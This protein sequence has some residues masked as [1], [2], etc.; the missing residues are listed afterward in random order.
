[1][2]DPLLPDPDVNDLIY[3]RLDNQLSDEDFAAIEERLRTDRK[4]REHFVRLADLD[5]CLY[6]EF[7]ESTNSVTT[8][9]PSTKSLFL[10]PALRGSLLSA[11]ATVI[12]FST[13]YLLK[14][15]DSD[16]VAALDRGI[17]FSPTPAGHS[18]RSQAESVPSSSRKI[19]FVADE[20]LNTKDAAVLV[21]VDDENTGPFL[22]GHRFKPGIVKLTQGYIQL[23]FICG[24]IVGLKGPGELRIESKDAATI[25]SG[26]VAAHVPDRARGFVLHAPSAAIVDLGT[27]FGVRIDESGDAEVKVQKG[28]VELSLL[29]DDGSTLVSERVDDSKAVLVD[30]SLQKLTQR[31]LPSETFPQIQSFD[32]KPL[33]I[34]DEYVASVLGAQPL[35]YWRFEGADQHRFL[36][37][38]GSQWSATEQP[39][40][41]P[42][43][44]IRI[45]DG[46][47][48]FS[49]SASPRFLTIDD[50]IPGLNER[51]YSI[52]FWMKPDDLT[53][54]T[55]VGVYP[56]NEPS[57][58]LHLNVIEIATETFLIHEPGAVRFLHRNPP[59]RLSNLGTNV[60]SQGICIPYQWQHVVAV[61][62]LDSIELYFNGELVRRVDVADANG[63]GNYRILVGQLKGGTTERQFSGAMDEL[64]V[65]PKGLTA[66][67]I[68][69]HY[70]MI[71]RQK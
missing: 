59:D 28:E 71:A 41:Q 62:N 50:G 39:I 14:P 31:I 29:G 6:D 68:A 49:R 5:A 48:R 20:T 21:L 40:D 54:A 10:R 64:A 8:V 46:H 13:W 34:T 23:E 58:K 3:R 55:C 24:A 18:E 47:V 42:T 30:R 60:F 69:L 33:A 1:M 35:I 63:A 26:E 12:M 2:T 43:E 19:E 32:E 65:Y 67:E 16:A 4:F 38:A 44:S 66:A 7:S 56:Q 36:N 37:D 51:A 57:A 25:F 53:H 45:A 15:D 22:P 9:L 61:K 27:D 17:G 11:V 52:E 70:S